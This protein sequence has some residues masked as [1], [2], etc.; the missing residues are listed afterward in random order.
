M[1]EKEFKSFNFDLDTKYK[2]MLNTSQEIIEYHEFVSD[3]TCEPPNYICLAY[4]VKNCLPKFLK[5][6]QQLKEKL[7]IN[8]KAIEEASSILKYYIPEDYIRSCDTSD[9][10][11]KYELDTESWQYKIYEILNMKKG[12]K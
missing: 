12:E 8:E 1:N 4:D 10:V 9:G 3:G 5:E 7:K 6:Y 11:G 2:D